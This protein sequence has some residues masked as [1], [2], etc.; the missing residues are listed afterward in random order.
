MVQ[1]LVL[2]RPWNKYTS[3]SLANLKPRVSFVFHTEAAN[4]Q[5][6]VGADAALKLLLTDI[7]RQTIVH[8]RYGY[9]GYGKWSRNA[10]R[11]LIYDH[12]ATAGELLSSVEGIQGRPLLII[13]WPG[14]P[15]ENENLMTS[16]S[17]TALSVRFDVVI[18]ATYLSI[19]T[20]T[21]VDL[22]RQAQ[23]H[24]LLVVFSLSK[25]V[26]I[27]AARLGG[28]VGDPN[29]LKS[30]KEVE[31]FRWDLFQSAVAECAFS[32]AGIQILSAH[33]GRLGELASKIR[34]A[35]HNAGMQ[36]YAGSGN[37]FV[38][39]PLHGKNVAHFPSSHFQG[40]LYPD[41]NLMRLDCNNHNLELIRAMPQASP[42]GADMVLS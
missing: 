8:P 21:F 11:V 36:T 27:P 7:P 32:E 39:V 10:D 3:G 40:K 34:I 33:A 30:Q 42:P 24:G 31:K 2:E 6:T 5:L 9:P 20:E 22:C 38:S 18:D 23:H 12:K 4:V 14:N 28:I 1:A 16:E 25:A 35:L 37:N 13:C 29:K 41:L 17:L 26:G 19:Y 15:V